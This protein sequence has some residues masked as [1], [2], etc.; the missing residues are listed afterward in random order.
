MHVKFTLDIYFVSKQQLSLECRTWNVTLDHH[1]FSHYL[2][3]LRWLHNPNSYVPEQLATTVNTQSE[4][5][6][7]LTK[8]WTHFLL[9]THTQ[10]FHIH[11]ISILARSSFLI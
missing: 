4:M 5:T 2:G 11:R 6:Q 3:R 9:S 8:T 1:I 10:L 7:L